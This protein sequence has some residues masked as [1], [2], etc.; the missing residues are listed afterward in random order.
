MLFDETL[1][2]SDVKNVSWKNEIEKW[3]SY[4]KNKEEL[5]RFIP[6]L[7]K[8]KSRKRSETFAEISSAYLLESKLNLKVTG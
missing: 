4:I 6:R 3:L 8:M 7:T 5:D 1:G 2:N